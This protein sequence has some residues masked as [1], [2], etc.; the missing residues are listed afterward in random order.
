[1]KRGTLQLLE[2]PFLRLDYRVPADTAPGQLC[3]APLGG[4]W[5]VGVTVSSSTDASP[6]RSLRDAVPIPVPALPSWLRDLVEDLPHVGETFRRTLPGA[7]LPPDLPRGP[8]RYLRLRPAPSELQP[9]GHRQR[10][11]VERFQRAGR[12]WM[13]ADRLMKTL[14]VSRAWLDRLVAR[15]WLEERER[16]PE[17]SRGR[18]QPPSWP[19]SPPTLPCP[20]PDRPPVPA[21][22]QALPALPYAERVAC[23][24][25]WQAHRPVLVLVPDEGLLHRWQEALPEGVPF[26]SSLP[27]PHRQAVW[28]GVRE[29]RLRVV[30]GTQAALWLPFADP[31]LWVADEPWMDPFHDPPLSVWIR[32]AEAVRVFFSGMPFPILHRFAWDFPREFPPLRPWTVRAVPYG[33]EDALQALIREVQRGLRRG[34]QVAIWVARR[35]VGWVQCGACGYAPLCPACGHVLVLHRDRGK[36]ELYCHR[37]GHRIHPPEQC[38]SCGGETWTLQGVGTQRGQEVLQQALQ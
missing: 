26:A 21:K 22:L 37:C 1:M 35:G 12:R 14:G 30:V 38:P 19:A 16:W 34:G 29:G 13:R 17:V 2:P 8:L 10:A 5:T 20:A 6:A 11:L 18:L 32:R 24:R 33:K 15:G 36:H 23:V 9:R 27:L 4:R 7:L 31:P 25:A 28:W 3:W